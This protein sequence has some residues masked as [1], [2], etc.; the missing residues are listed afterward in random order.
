MGK[1]RNG[2]IPLPATGLDRGERSGLRRVLCCISLAILLMN[3]LCRPLSD[4]AQHEPP[5][6]RWHSVDAQGH[7]TVT[8]YFFWSLTCPHCKRAIPFLTQ[9]QSAYDWLQVL[10][11]ELTEHPDNIQRYIKMATALGQ[12]ARSVPAFL[13]CEEMLVG[14]ATAATTGK[15]LEHKLVDCHQRLQQ[16][17]AVTPSQ[18]ASRPTMPSLV[19]PGIG[20]IDPSTLSLP[21]MTVIIAGLDAFNP[22]AFFVLFFLLSLLVH[23]HNRRRMLLIGGTFVLCSGGM[24]FIF[25]AAWLNLFLLMGHVRGMTLGAGAVACI[26]ALLNIKDYFWFQRGVSLSIPEQAKPGL[27]KRMRGLVHATR[28]PSMM[29]GTIVLAIIANTYELLCTAGFPMVF[30]RILTLANLPSSA[31][32]LYLVFYNIVYVIPLGI[33]VLLCTVTLGSH[34]LQEQGGRRLKLLSGSMMFYLSLVLLFAPEWLDNVLTAIVVLI[35]AVASTA[36]IVV[37]ERVLLKFRARAI[38]SESRP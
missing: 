14:Y 24:Y 18:T 7:V 22:C 29:V 37:A 30:T 38:P 11:L 8:V 20:Q 28:L 16:G 3:V 5:P 4:A 34:K 1:K 12:E 35:A 19:I 13:F 36:L 23:A 31:Y 27:F 33:I 21:V 9:L 10:S 17:A 2:V 6:S 25:M 15:V 32:Y 26:M